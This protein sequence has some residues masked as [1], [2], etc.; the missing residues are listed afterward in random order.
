MFHNV[1]LRRFTTF[2]VEHLLYQQYQW[3]LINHNILLR[4]VNFYINAYV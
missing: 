1:V 2:T 4:W 3:E